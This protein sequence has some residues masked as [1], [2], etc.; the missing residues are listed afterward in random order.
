MLAFV[1]FWHLEIIVLFKIFVKILFIF[2]MTCFVGR[3][4]LSMT[5]LFLYFYKWSNVMWNKQILTFV[6]G[7]STKKVIYRFLNNFVCMKMHISLTHLELIWKT[8][9]Y[10]S[11]LYLIPAS[12]I[13]WLF[14][15]MNAAF[16]VHM[17]QLVGTYSREV[18]G[19]F[20]LRSI[21]HLVTVRRSTFGLRCC[22][23][24]GPCSERG[25][26]DS[27]PHQV[28]FVVKGTNTFCDMLV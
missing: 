12:E 9:R 27:A 23:Y 18:H 2:V 20:L 16:A 11:C 10:I 7:G 15:M 22:V 14:D 4:T 21:N 17:N 8:G 1:D 5:Y 3:Y 19:T 28:C 6:D 25:V 26:S 24:I 13:S